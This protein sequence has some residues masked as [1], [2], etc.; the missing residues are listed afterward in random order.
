MATG[1]STHVRTGTKSISTTIST[2]WDNALVSSRE[3][4]PS[5]TAV[6]VE[7]GSAH[8]GPSEHVL[9]SSPADAASRCGALLP[10][11]GHR[12]PAFRACR[13]RRPDLLRRR[14]GPGQLGRRRLGL[15]GSALHPERHAAQPHEVRLE[16]QPPPSPHRGRQERADR[17]P[18][19]GSAQRQNLRGPEK[20]RV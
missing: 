1:T 20:V 19:R 18:R 10:V 4:L 13:R 7:P 5:W 16:T 11:L 15:A 6:G 9:L 3:R 8:V 12:E 2:N 17:G 14:L